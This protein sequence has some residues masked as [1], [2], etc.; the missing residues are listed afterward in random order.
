MQRNRL[1]LFRDLAVLLAALVALT[2]MGGTAAYAMSRQVVALQR[3]TVSVRSS[4]TSSRKAAATSTASAAPQPYRVVGLGDSVPAGTNC[5][6]TSYVVRIGQQAARQHGRPAAV[7]NLAQP[8]LTTAGLAAQLRRPAVR[9][10]IADADLVII[11]IGANDFDPDLLT[12]S[13][14][15]PAT[16]LSCYQSVLA[17]QRS[18]LSSVLAQV[19]ALQTRSGGRILVT[20]YWNVFRDGQVG[21]DQGAAYVE[22]GNALTRADNALI[23]SV[24]AAHGDTYVDIYTPF[25]GDGSKDDTALLASDG[26]HPNAAG[27]ALIARTLLGALA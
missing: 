9:S 27:H 16:A 23:A 8:G 22:G 4:A 7:T 25:K 15:Q 11:T 1:R 20:G 2:V 14:C 18:L 13:D 17:T 24:S 21:R 12:A 19:N 26:D 6:C 5:G 10:A 3:S